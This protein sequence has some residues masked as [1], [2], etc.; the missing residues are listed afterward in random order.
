MLKTRNNWLYISK[1]IILLLIAFAALSGDGAFSQSPDAGAQRHNS[2]FSPNPKKRAQKGKQSDEG[3]LKPENKSVED[4]SPTTS[5][6]TTGRSVAS[7]T[8]EIAKRASTTAMLPTDIYKIGVGDV[9][10]INLQ[11]APSDQSTYFTVLKD[12]TV[13]YPLAN[14]FVEVAGLTTDQIEDILKPKIKLFENPVLTVRVRE[15]SSHTFTVLGLVDKPGEKFLQR[16]AVPLY[17]V[18]AEAVVQPKAVCASIRHA[19]GQVDSLDLRD[20][21]YED[22]LIYPGDIIEFKSDEPGTAVSAEPQFYFIGGNIHSGGQKDFHAGITLT[23]AIL[24]SGGLRKTGEKN[25]T[26]RRKNGDGLLV[27]EHFDLKAIKE[28]KVADPAI[29]AGDTIEVGS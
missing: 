22:V 21:K 12:G 28:G 1:R 18:R 14:E 13:D 23:Q 2:P 11:G 3:V 24:A 26:V 5:P 15:F 10:S 7:K 6:D 8:L 16:E 25:V 19:A 17:V 29:L 27:S 4:S 9:L 20:R